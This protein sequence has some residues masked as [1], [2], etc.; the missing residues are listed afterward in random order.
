MIDL[1]DH[2]FAGSPIFIV[3]GRP[4]LVVTELLIQS[5]HEGFTTAQA[6]PDRKRRIHH[7]QISV[8][9]YGYIRLYPC[10]NP[11]LIINRRYWQQHIND[12][13]QHLS[14]VHSEYDSAMF[15][16]ARTLQT[17]RYS[18]STSKTYFY[19]FKDFLN[20]TS[21]KPLHYIGKEEILNYQLHLVHDREVSRS[22]Q[23]QSIN[24]IK[25]YLEK[26]L[27][28][29]RQTFE[30]ERPR[31][32]RKLPLVLSQEEIARLL[33]SVKNLKHKTILTT[34]YSAGLRRSEVINLQIRDVLSDQMQLVVRN[35]KGQ[36]DRLTV[37]SREL[38]QLLRQYY[39][40]YRPKQFL[41][42]GPDGGPYSA[43]SIR[44]ILSRALKRANIQ[45]PATVHTLRHSFA[46][47]LLENGTNL[48]YI[49]TLL[50]H[51]SPKTTE[52]YTH[53][54]ADRLTEVTSPLDTLHKK[55][56]I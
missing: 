44:K 38:L 13:M 5:S 47:H 19:M 35:G 12:V 17:H 6:L 36:K 10:I 15:R 1:Q 39:V 37:L 2:S 28:H 55:G 41:F 52:I 22:Y 9:I 11:F 26:V 30:L 43:S 3:E 31:K 48:R 49:Q 51:G 14:T 7:F 25:F 53:V 46:T 54:C 16:F 4:A 32:E 21:P 34:I 20:Y 42:E 8:S 33:G 45:K 18:E 24:A 23:N 29:D 56:Y 27:G 50:G 40:E